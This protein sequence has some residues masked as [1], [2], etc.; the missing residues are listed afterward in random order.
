[1]LGDKRTREGISLDVSGD[2]DAVYDD[3]Y[4]RVEHGKFYVACAGKPIY[5]LTRKEFLI[6]SRLVRAMGRPVTKQEIWDFAWEGDAKF[7]RDTLRVHVAGLRRKLSPF[8]LDIVA[9]VHVGYRLMSLA[10]RTDG[11]VGET[12]HE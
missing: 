6:L 3:G 8:G 2:E 7:N 11:R 12:F 1:M 10:R 4:L 5:N 9:V